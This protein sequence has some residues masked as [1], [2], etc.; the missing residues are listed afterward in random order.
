MTSSTRRGPYAKSVARQREILDAA[1]DVFATHGYRA[2][3]L[4][5]IADRVGIDASTILHHFANKSVLLQR[6]LEDRDTRSLADADPNPA[7]GPADTPAA[8]LRLARANE[9]IPGIVELY[10]LLAAESATP[11]HPSNEYFVLR[12]S[13]VRNEFTTAFREMADAGLL[14]PGVDPEFA[15]VS[16]LALW[17]GVQVQWMHDP[18]AVDVTET[19]RKHLQLLTTVD[20]A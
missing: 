15:A 16:T 5:E 3:S 18:D 4:K 11:D 10:T 7:A 8:F 14:R 20:L 13:R 2:G 1:G 6:V 19:L 17:D 12:Y 9:K